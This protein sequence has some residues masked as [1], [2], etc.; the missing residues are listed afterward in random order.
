MQS[1]KSGMWYVGMQDHEL[2][3][4]FDFRKCLALL[5]EAHFLN[6]KMGWRLVLMMNFLLFSMIFFFPFPVHH[7]SWNL[8]ACILFRLT[9]TIEKHACK[10]TISLFEGDR[11]SYLFFLL[12]LFSI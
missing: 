1:T 8:R 4:L 9:S 11:F 3:R 10:V 12:F 5:T 7:L 2:C 6:T